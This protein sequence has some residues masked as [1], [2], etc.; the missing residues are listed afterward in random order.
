MSFP[1]VCSTPAAPTKTGFQLWLSENKDDLQEEHPD[2]SEA[3]LMV[4]AAKAFKEL[5]KEDK[6][7]RHYFFFQF[8][9]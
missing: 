7:V 9:T 3:D 1:C 8:I 5:P 2:L 4:A 6:Q